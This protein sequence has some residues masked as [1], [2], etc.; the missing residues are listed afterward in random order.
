MI[1][2]CEEC[3]EELEFSLGLD[4]EE[5]ISGIEFHFAEI[6]RIL[7]LDLNEESLKKTPNRVA[8]MFVLEL[9]KGLDKEQFPKITTQ[10]NKFN[11]H[12]MLLESNINVRSICEHHFVPILGRCHI[13]YIPG[14]RIIGLSKLNRITEY[15]SRRPQVQERLTKQIQ[16]ELQSILQTESVAVLIDAAHMCVRLRGVQ[17]SDSS[18]RTC[19]LG[20][21]FLE[22]PWREQFLTAIAPVH[23]VKL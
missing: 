21:L 3:N 6:L 15:Y 9:F 4:L 16:E 7:G 18:T 22:S 8:K 20:G 1:N 14:E 12:G 5:K 23:A 2:S 13:A 19:E 11:F 10:E 17:D